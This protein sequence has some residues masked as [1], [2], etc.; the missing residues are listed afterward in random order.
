MRSCFKF[1]S[2]ALMV[3]ALLVSLSSCQKDPDTEKT[4]GNITLY[5]DSLEAL[6]EGDM[7]RVNYDIAERQ[8]GVELVAECKDEWISSIEVRYSLIDITVECNRS[9]A[10]RSATIELNYG[11][12]R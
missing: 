9:G 12:A 10:E 6:P 2:V 1:L 11:G 5:V 7:L 3:A 8:D 4:K